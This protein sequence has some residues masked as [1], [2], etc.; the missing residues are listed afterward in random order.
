M[1][2]IPTINMR[3]TGLNIVKL[4]ERAGLSVREL[5]EELRLDSPQA[6]YKWQ[7]GRGLPTLDNLVVL[8]AVLQAKIDEIIICDSNC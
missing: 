4:R 7:N 8:S 2:N 5:Q 1:C 3:K 6:I